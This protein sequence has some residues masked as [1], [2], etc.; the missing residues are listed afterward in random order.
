MNARFNTN[1]QKV[2]DRMLEVGVNG[3]L[4]EDEMVK[5]VFVFSDME[6]DRASRDLWETDYEAIERKFRAHGYETVP[7]IVFWN[8]RSSKSTPVT[9]DRKGVALL[10]GFSKNLLTL[11]LEE[12]GVIKPEIYKKL[13][14]KAKESLPESTSKKSKDELPLDSSSSRNQHPKKWHILVDQV[15]R[16][17]F[18]EKRSGDWG[19][20]SEIGSPLRTLP[21]SQFFKTRSICEDGIDLPSSPSVLSSESIAASHLPSPSSS[22]ILKKG[23]WTFK[24]IK[25]LRPHG[26]ELDPSW[27]HFTTGPIQISKQIEKKTNRIKKGFYVFYVSV[28]HIG[29]MTMLVQVRTII[30]FENGGTNLDR[31][32]SH[33]KVVCDLKAALFLAS[34]APETNWLAV[35]SG[36]DPIIRSDDINIPL[37]YTTSYVKL[38]SILGKPNFFYFLPSKSNPTVIMTCEANNPPKS[39]FHPAFTVT[40][41]KNSIPILLDRTNSHY[42]AWVELFTIQACASNVL[43]HIDSKTPRPADIDNPTWTRLDAVV[44]QWIYS[45]ISADLIQTIMK[46]GATAKELWDRLTEIFQDNKVTRVV[47]LEEQF[48]STLLDA[49]SNVA[50]YCDRL[51]FIADQLANVG[52]PISETKMVLQLVAGLNKGEYDTVAT[53]IQQ[54]DPLPSFNKASSQLLLEETRRQKQDNHIPQALTTQRVTDPSRANNPPDTRVSNS[55]GGY[56]GRR[57]GGGCNNRGRGRGGQNGGRNNSQPQ[58]YLV[59]SNTP[60]PHWQQAY[61]YPQTPPQWANPPCPYPTLPPTAQSNSYGP[62]PPPRTHR[63]PVPQSHIAS[64]MSSVYGQPMTPTELDQAFHTMHL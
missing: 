51:K 2:F 28:S 33:P 56:H 46:P 26:V 64:D 50:E 40:I 17:F 12:G 58:W 10:S 21:V 48:N 14:E 35:F 52:N 34:L 47:Y 41:V 4:G 7:E 29:A 18:G 60:Q 24:A 22:L 6:F 27:R 42:A 37:A 16:R 62:R 57:T 5:R 9:G 54:A 25:P 31:Y 8:L 49:F 19:C 61:N 45:T 30:K 20:F 23:E 63:Q 53:L 39:P 59:Q 1:F 55:R 36:Q 13:V 15:R 38:K 43:D 3:K 32:K 44:K 11:F